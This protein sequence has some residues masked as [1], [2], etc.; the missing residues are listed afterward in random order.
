MTSDGPPAGTGPAFNDFYREHLTYVWNALRRLGVSGSDLEDLTQEVFLRAFRNY[1]S[2][3][4]SRPLRP[5]LFAIAAR[6]TVDFKRMPRHAREVFEEPADA[7][8]QAPLPDASAATA[9][10]RRVL[11]ELL[12]ELEPDRRLVFIM[13]EYFEHTAG[14]IAEALEIPTNTAY[15][16]L[17][18]ARAQFAEL[19]SRRFGPEA[20]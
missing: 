5:W 9:Q 4:P 3:D 12:D 19:V 16:R 15:S 13:H 8:D 7:E 6:A 17:R 1:H 18:L 14:E 2:Y 11:H 10:E 20:R